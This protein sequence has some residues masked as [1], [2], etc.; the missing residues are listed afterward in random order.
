MRVSAD[1]SIDGEAEAVDAE[2]PTGV[3]GDS[4]SIGGGAVMIDEW[5]DG[6]YPKGDGLGPEVD[7]LKWE[8]EGLLS[9]V[10]ELGWAAPGVGLGSPD[11]ILAWAW[12]NSSSTVRGRSLL[13]H[14]DI[15]VQFMQ[16][17]PF[18]L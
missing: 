8:I 3:D 4:R 9:G 17:I 18:L 16:M 7:G 14:P 11:G 2:G 1:A 6:L 13:F 5:V 10:I 12:R 15:S